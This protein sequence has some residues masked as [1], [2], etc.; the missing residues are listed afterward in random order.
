MISH[1]AV[2]VIHS[3]LHLLL[4]WVEMDFHFLSPS[5]ITIITNLYADILIPFIICGYDKQNTILRNYGSAF[6][7]PQVNT[8]G[9]YS[10]TVKRKMRQSSCVILC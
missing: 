6:L 2:L 3:F 8:H 1:V 9:S 5:E 4:S 7:P 10:W